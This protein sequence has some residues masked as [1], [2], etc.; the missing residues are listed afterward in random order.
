[1]VETT[2]GFLVIYDIKGKN[3][4]VSPN[5][6]KITGYTRQEL[7]KETIW[8]TH[9]DDT[10]RSKEALESTLK[11]GNGVKNFEYRLVRKNGD[12]IYASSSWEPLKD[13]QGKITR[14]L[15]QT[16]D[17]TERKRAEEALIESEKK[18]RTLVE[19]AQEGIGI[20]DPE[21]NLTFVNQAFADMLGYEREQLLGKNLSQIS[22]K[23]EFAK[24]RKETEKRKQGESS[25]YEAKLFTK[26]GR[27]K[28]FYVSAV[29]I[30]AEDGSFGGTLGVLTDITE[31]KRAREQNLLLETSKALSRT[32]K[33]DQ[34]LKIATKKMAQALKADRCAVAFT[35]QNIES[36]T[37][38]HIYLEDGSSSPDLLGFTISTRDFYEANEFLRTKRYYQIANTR[39]DPIPQSLRKYFLRAG[40][41]S[42]LIIPIFIG[43]KLL[44]L[45]NVGSVRDLRNFTQE[46]IRLAQTITNQVAV[47]VQNSLLLEDIKGKHDQILNQTNILTRQ[48]KEKDILLKISRALSKTI[49]LEQVFKI[50]TEQVGVALDVDRCSIL[51]TT[52]DEDQVEIKSIYIKNQKSDARVLGRRFS[53]DDIPRIRKTI[54]KGKPLQVPNV[55]DLPRGS[56]TRKYCIEVGIKSMLCVPLFSGKRVLGILVISS[57]TD[58]KTFTNEE[59]KLIQTIANQV[60]VAIENA[61]LLEVVRKSSEDLRVLSSQLINVQ[62]DERKKIAQ[63]LHDEIGQMLFAMKMNLD[64]TKKNLPTNLE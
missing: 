40:V 2:P 61:R 15:M 18:Y 48:Y 22:D 64:V 41:K 34:V 17:I 57:V 43:K 6:E 10:Q 29:P 16:V 55:C 21:E 35:D 39:T 46:E 12:I 38:K 36:A 1:M 51:M 59:I 62:E 45:F 3:V 31:I 8:W 54:V 53:P 14:L 42:T 44:G 11:T 28:Y 19:T 30:R 26:K 24:F 9:E 25:K 20:N 58:F 27:P 50:A 52:P 13:E 63:E 33:L 32:L 4:Y 7:M 47:A 37:V 60:A 5:C 23:E 49:D 56:E